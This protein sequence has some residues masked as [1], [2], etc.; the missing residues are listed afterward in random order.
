MRSIGGVCDGTGCHTAGPS[1][2]VS[3]TDVCG[4]R[5]LRIFVT[6]TEGSILKN[7]QGRHHCRPFLYEDLSSRL[8]R[9]AGVRLPCCL[10]L[11]GG[12][13]VGRFPCEV[14]VVAAEVSVCCG[15]AVDGTAQVEGL[16]DALGRELEVVAHERGEF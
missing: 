13:F 14:G 9:A 3:H 5:T 15:L 11:E 4:G 12:G 8:L 16:D 6:N 1:F 7:N 2:G 10:L